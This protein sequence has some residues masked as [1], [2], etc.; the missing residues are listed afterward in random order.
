M[1]VILLK[2]VPGTGRR[3]EVKD[4]AAGYASNFLLPKKLAIVATNSSVQK[5]TLDKAKAESTSKIQ[6][7]LALKNLASLDGASITLTE[8]AN[9]EGHLF[10]GVHAKEISERIKKELKLDIPE[11]FIKLEKPIKVVGES[12][13]EI[14]SFGKKVTLT[15]TI[16]KA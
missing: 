12:S 9:D 4:V 5:V 11:N 15:V 3:F 16:E 1:K 2:D 13:I 8:K 14:E 10:A 6:Q 7:D